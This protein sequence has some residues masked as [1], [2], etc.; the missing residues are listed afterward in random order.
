MSRL[1]ILWMC[2]LAMLLPSRADDA[3]RWRK[4]TLTDSGK[5]YWWRPG[6]NREDPEVSLHEPDDIWKYGET[7]KGTP[8]IWRTDEYGMP[9]VQLWRRAKLESGKPY[10][11]RT[12]QGQLQEVRLTDPFEL[13]GTNAASNEA[14]PPVIARHLQRDEL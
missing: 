13:V 3:M 8:Y 5:T 10:W 2:L 4:G 7:D 6:I 1:I 12:A 11:W 14:E 9:E